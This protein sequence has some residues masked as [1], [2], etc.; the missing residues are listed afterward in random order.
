MTKVSL[1]RGSSGRSV[2]IWSKFHLLWAGVQHHQSDYHQSSSSR[3]TDGD[4]GTSGTAAVI[5]KISWLVEAQFPGLIKRPCAGR[6]L[7]STPTFLTQDYPKVFGPAPPW[8]P[9]SPL[10]PQ[11]LWVKGWGSSQG[12]LTDKSV[13]EFK[14]FQFALLPGTVL[15]YN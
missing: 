10:L 5:P 3:K 1:L 12:P 8:T 4:V 6:R 14:L 7:G 13:F 11:T 9:P 2:S 15:L